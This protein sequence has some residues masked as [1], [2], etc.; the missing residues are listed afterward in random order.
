[1]RLKPQSAGGCEWIDSDIAPPSGFVAMAV[2]FTMMAAAKRDRELVTDF[3]SK[4]P[5]LSKA[6]VMSI[7]RTAAASEARLLGHV[8]DVLPIPNPTGLSQGQETFVDRLRLAKLFLRP[9]RG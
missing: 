9:S 5:V 8:L 4:G 3:S 1:M 7:A 6:Q 2:E